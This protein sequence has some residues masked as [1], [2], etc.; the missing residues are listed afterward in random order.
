MRYFKAIVEYDGTDFRGFQW[1]HAT[2][3]VQGELEKAISLRTGQDVRITGAGRTDS[4]VHA[5]GQVISFPAD[6]RIPTEKMAIALNSALSRDVSIRSIEETDPDFNARFKASSRTYVYLIINRKTPSALWRRYTAFEVQ[7]L[8]V[9]A[10]RQAAALL[11]GEQDFAAFT[12]A[13]QPDEPTFRDVMQCRVSAWRSLI[14]VRIEANAFLRGMVRNIVGTLVAIGG[15]AY[16]PEQIRVIQASRDRK[17]A[18]P[19]APPQGLCLMK[20]RY[21]ERKVY[22]RREITEEQS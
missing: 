22:A 16:A 18:G 9:D 10:M 4:G 21:G 15:G 8:D 7:P 17:M 14:L 6:T 1:Q 20:V 3:T 12:N 5:L 13:L 19:S 11:I 2:R